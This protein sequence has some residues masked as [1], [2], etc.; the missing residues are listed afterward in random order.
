MA[1]TEIIVDNATGSN[2]NGGFPIG[3]IYPVT[4][5]G[6]TFTQ[7]G[8]AGGNDRFAAAAGTPFSGCAVDDLVSSYA[9]G[10]AAPTGYIG[11]ITAIN[12]GGAS[13]DLHLTRFS[14]TRPTTGGSRTVKVGGAL[15]GMSGA[16]GFPFGFAVGAL[17]NAALDPLCVNIKGGTTYEITAAITHALNGVI[18]EGYTTTLH[19]GGL[20]KIGGDSASP[21]APYT[22]LTVSG[23]GNKLRRMW[24]DDNGGTTPGQSVGNNCM[25]E[26]S[27]SGDLA[28]FCRFSNAYRTGLRVGGA[29]CQASDCE[30]YANNRDDAGGFGGIHSSVSAAIVRC[31]AYNHAAGTD[32]CGFS[33]AGNDDRVIAFEDCISFN[34]AGNGFEVTGGDHSIRMSGCLSIDNAENGIEFNATTVTTSLLVI[35]NSIIYGSGLVGIRNASALRT[36]PLVT[37]CA[38]GDN[39]GGDTTNVP[40]SF[41]TNKVT[42]SGDPF[43]D[44]TNGDFRL[45][46]TAGA[47]ADC[48]AAGIGTFFINT[49]NLSAGAST[50]GFPDIGA[51]QHEETAPPAGGQTSYTFG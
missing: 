39:A 19:D 22:M 42:L 32:S 38:F 9:D 15:A 5:T 51:V 2:L 10:A 21:T 35:E 37:N 8:G 17:T 26:L 13:I 45:N 14:G 34:N 40:T 36:G 31:I 12:G 20:C 27:G 29:G 16:V 50:V 23:S 24:F 41:I 7:A 1:F 11:I 3:G 49:A 43:E 48:R 25:V 33:A 18:F 4:S 46:D 47:G 6:G 28:Q 44:K 30:A